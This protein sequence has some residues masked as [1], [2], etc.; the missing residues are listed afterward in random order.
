YL[1]RSSLGVPSLAT[2]VSLGRNEALPDSWQQ[3]HVGL[4]AVIP[5]NADGL[6][7][8]QR[9]FGDT[10]RERG[11]ATSISAISTPVSWYQFSFLFSAGFS[12]G[13]GTRTATPETKARDAEILRA[14]VAAAG[15]HGW[16]EYRAA[17]YFQ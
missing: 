13:G 5:R 15:E 1:W 6:F 14:L 9:V 11:V 7:E 4:F 12:S 3:N 8:A 2:W 17:P 16:A 10:L